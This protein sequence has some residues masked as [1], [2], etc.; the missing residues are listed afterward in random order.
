M[1]TCMMVMRTMIMRYDGEVDNLVLPSLE[2]IRTKPMRGGF[3]R[4]GGGYRGGG[5]GGYHGG[6]GYQRR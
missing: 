6:G 4:G 2:P 1:N 5:G 3:Q